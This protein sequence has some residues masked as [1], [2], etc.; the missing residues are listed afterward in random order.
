M[1]YRPLFLAL[2]FCMLSGFSSQPADERKMQQALPAS[3]HPLWD[4]LAKTKITVDDKKGIYNATVPAEVK[5]LSGKP[6]TIAGFM[7]PLEAT[8]KF[9]HFLLSK[10]TPTCAYCPPGEPNE[11]IDVWMKE[12]IA[13]TEELLSIKGEFTLMNDHEMGLFFKIKLAEIKP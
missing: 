4:T 2:A 3:Q 8:S 9:K 7:L 12:P 6:M 10:R 13:Y 11:V 1:Q 5:A